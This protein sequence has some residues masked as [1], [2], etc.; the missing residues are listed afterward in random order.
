MSIFTRRTFLGLSA[1]LPLMATALKAGGHASVH[2]VSIEG[3]SFVPNMLEAKVGDKVVFTNRDGAPHTATATDGSFD[4]GRLKRD[5][6][7]ELEITE[8]GEHAYFC[9]FHRSMTGTIIAS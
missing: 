7:F 6:S 4:S 8:A 5:Q 2:E 3:F 1:A 9:A